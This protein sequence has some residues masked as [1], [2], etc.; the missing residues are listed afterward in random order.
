MNQFSFLIWKCIRVHL[1]GLQTYL[2]C[3]SMCN[4]T[5]ITRQHMSFNTTT[6]KFGNQ[7]RS[8]WAYTIQRVMDTHQNPINSKIRLE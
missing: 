3:N 8:I 5:D 6:M 1:L 2:F 7:I 4:F